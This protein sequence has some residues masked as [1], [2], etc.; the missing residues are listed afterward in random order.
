MFL[1]RS[2]SR[3]KLWKYFK[4]LLL[5]LIIYLLIKYNFNILLIFKLFFNERDTIDIKFKLDIVQ[6]IE[7]SNDVRI[8]ATRDDTLSISLAKLNKHTSHGVEMSMSM[9][10]VS[11]RK[12]ENKLL[13]ICPLMPY[14]ARGRVGVNETPISYD[15]LNRKYAARFQTDAGGWWKPSECRV[16]LNRVAII[17][18]YRNRDLHLRLFLNHMHTFLAPQLIEYSFYIVEQSA[19]VADFNRAALLNIGSREAL[20][21]TDWNCFIFHDVDLVP[22]DDRNFYHCPMWPRHMS[23]EVNTLDDKLPYKEIFGGVSAVT[24]QHFELLNGF[25]YKFWVTLLIQPCFFSL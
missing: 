18:P 11:S 5:V 3:R 16:E 10:N 21:D 1:L 13:N 7:S 8:A 14:C 12:E 20:K 23:I 4:T 2:Q 6:S 19:D 24:R 15:E 22:L 9:N 17:V 25:S